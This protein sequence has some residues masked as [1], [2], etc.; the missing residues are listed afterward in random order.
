MSGLLLPGR[1][2]VTAIAT[3]Y[4]FSFKSSLDSNSTIPG[5]Y[6]PLNNSKSWGY[7][8]DHFDLV[9]SNPVISSPG[10]GDKI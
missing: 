5:P 4:H 7:A 1:N 6:I 10:E 9:V 3:F 8:K 2:N